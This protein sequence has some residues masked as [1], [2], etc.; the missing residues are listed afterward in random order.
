MHQTDRR[1]ICSEASRCVLDRDFGLALLAAGLFCLAGWYGGITSR[2][3]PATFCNRTEQPRVVGDEPMQA[4]TLAAT[5]MATGVIGLPKTQHRS[6]NRIKRPDPCCRF[7]AGR[8]P[9]ATSW[10]T[11]EH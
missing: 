10:S 8:Y 1:L 7:L 5:A 2:F 11:P 6:S 3:G 9:V 4:S